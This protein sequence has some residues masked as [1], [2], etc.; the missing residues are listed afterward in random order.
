M[1]LYEQI[2]RAR[3]R[4]ANAWEAAKAVLDEAGTAGR[5]LEGELLERY[6][7]ADS[8]VESLTREIDALERQLENE[9]ADHSFIEEREERTGIPADQYDEVFRSY[10]RGGIGALEHDERQVLRRGFVAEERAQSV[11][12]SSGGGYTVPEGFW[13][14]LQETLLAF[15]GAV[16]NV[17]LITT[18][19]GNDL[20]WPTVDDT[21]NKGAI[22]A[23]NTQVSE[24]DVTFGV[25]SLGAYKYTSKL[26]RVSLELLQDSAIDV[27][28]LIARKL[29]ERLARIY[30]EHLT[31][32]SGSGQPDGLATSPTTGKTFASAT[33][34]T[35]DELLDLIH[36]V[37]QAYR[38]AP[39]VSWMFN[40]TTALGV[41]KIVDGD[42][43]KAWQPGLVQ[44]QPDRLLGYPY[45][46]NT[47]MPG[48]TT[49]NVSMLFGDFRAGYVQRQVRG[50]QLVRF[51]EKYMD[52]FQI[53]FTAF[54]RM[55]GTKDDT[56]AYKAGVQA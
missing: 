17:N 7:R 31:T 21:S 56:S 10:L 37:D 32:G 12:T 44:G 48:P 2:K 49:G 19:S 25:N 9:R 8:D 52:Y 24:Q 23:E 26:I 34:Q 39:G 46:V 3:E 54:G 6:E 41:R 28:A 4:R 16:G 53:G 47:D 30:N 18:G 42:G 22:L 13:N 27:E 20:P 45:I 29:G 36:S 50:V 5:G 15:G 11:G 55:D 38:G 14:R 40:D 43:N 51:D 33:V 35:H 1:D